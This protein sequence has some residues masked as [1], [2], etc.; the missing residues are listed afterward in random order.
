MPVS[1]TCTSL[2]HRTSWKP[3]T[4][5]KLKFQAR[6]GT[7][8]TSRYSQIQQDYQHNSTYSYNFMYM[9]MYIYLFIY[10]LYFV[11]VYIYTYILYVYIYIHILYVYINR[12]IISMLSFYILYIH[13]V[14]LR[15]QILFKFQLGILTKRLELL[16]NYFVF[17]CIGLG[18]CCLPCPMPSVPSP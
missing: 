18:A 13:W 15:L 10:L 8:R 2:K 9:C 17:C 6:Q 16:H 7:T 11:C 12:Y 1:K 14:L 5:S 4:G 3:L